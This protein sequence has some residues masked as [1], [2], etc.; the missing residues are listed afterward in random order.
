MPDVETV[1]VTYLTKKGCFLHPA[2]RKPVSPVYSP[3][4]QKTQ[5]KDTQRG[6]GH[7]TETREAGLTPSARA[8]AALSAVA[9]A[10]RRASGALLR[11]S[12]CMSLR[13]RLRLA[14]LA[15]LVI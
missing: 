13:M 6:N 12:R 5:H 2:Q 8:L 15:R 9:F 4:L 7:D 11:Q 10:F 3:N 1:T 14:R